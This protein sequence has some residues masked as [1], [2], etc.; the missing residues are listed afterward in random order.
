VAYKQQL[1]NLLCKLDDTPLGE[2]GI[3]PISAAKVL[4]FDP[5]RFTSEGAFAVQRKGPDPGRIRQAD[6]LVRLAVTAAGS[7][8]PACHSVRLGLRVGEAARR[9]LGATKRTGCPPSGCRDLEVMQGC[10]V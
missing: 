9:L 8:G 6:P 4:A 7:V 3:G 1:A 10:G 5:T 2:S